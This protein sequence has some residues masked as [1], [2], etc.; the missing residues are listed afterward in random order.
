MSIA[1]KIPDSVRIIG[2][3]YDIVLLPKAA[4]PNEYGLC[5]SERQR[6]HVMV[7]ASNATIID[8]LIHECLHAIDFSMHLELTERQ[9]HAASSGLAALFLDN[10]QLINLFKEAICGRVGDGRARKGA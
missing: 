2:K 6:I 9:V 3:T 7:D 8:T 10:P 5:D 4:M 1:A